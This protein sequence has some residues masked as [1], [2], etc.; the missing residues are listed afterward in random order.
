[1][2]TRP[3]VPGTAL[4]FGILGGWFVYAGIRNVPLIDGL[5]EL[6]RGDTPTPRE[7]DDNGVAGSTWENRG[8]SAPASSTLAGEL[9]LSLFGVSGTEDATSR[10]LVGNAK[11]AYFA[12][13]AAFPNMTIHGWGTRP[14]PTDHDDGLALD[15]MTTDDPTARKIILMFR[16]QPGA[17]YWI[18]NRQIASAERGWTPRPYSGPNP[19]TDHVHLS[20]T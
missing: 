8:S 7:T 18:W 5:R 20:Y 17:K 9:G 10:R 15:L 4:V 12:F 16:S 14:N 13:R 3:T 11:R 19:H 1:V 6:L 2:T